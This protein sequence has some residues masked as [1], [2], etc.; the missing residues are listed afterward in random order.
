MIPSVFNEPVE[1]ISETELFHTKFGK[2]QRCDPKATG[3]DLVIVDL[4]VTEADHDPVLP[5]TSNHAEVDVVVDDSPTY[6]EPPRGAEMS[7]SGPECDKNGLVDVESL[8]DIDDKN[9]TTQP[10]SVSKS[11]V[12]P[13]SPACTRIRETYLGASQ[14][15][16]FVRNVNRNRFALSLPSSEATSVPSVPANLQK[17][18][19][20]A[21]RVG[22]QCV[23]SHVSVKLPRRRCVAS[24]P[25]T[26]MPCHTPPPPLS[27][28]TPTVPA[29]YASG[30]SPS[31]P[32][33][34]VNGCGDDSEGRQWKRLRRLRESAT[35]AAA[36]VDQK[37]EM[38]DT[39]K[40]SGSCDVA[41]TENGQASEST[42][43]F[44]RRRERERD[45]NDSNEDVRNEGGAAFGESSSVGSAVSEK[46]TLLEGVTSSGGGETDKE[47]DSNH[48]SDHRLGT[49]SPPGVVLHD[50][51]HVTECGQDLRAEVGKLFA[52]RGWP[53][54]TDGV[55]RNCI[56]VMLGLGKNLAS[57]TPTATKTTT[58]L[59]WASRSGP[60]PSTR[61]SNNTAIVGAAIL[62]VYKY[63]D[64]RR[65]GCL[66]F[67]VSAE[68]GI[69]G[70]L[71][72]LALR[73]LAR[74]D[75][76]CLFSGVDLS[77][78]K[79]LAAHTGWGFRAVERQT[80]AN[81]GLNF[82]E[83]GD[84]LYMSLPVARPS[85]SRG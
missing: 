25:H 37:G 15:F 31:T 64:R 16:F 79:A 19:V 49:S 29:P 2:A 50:F 61:N 76:W 22:L 48:S 55:T 12:R 8:S 24:L 23:R 18:V 65:C 38:Y 6:L 46:D 78:A 81:A 72:G 70:V 39:P 67:I 36:D 74:H 27:P 1:D 62:S 14:N 63:R 54:P 11:T 83:T 73:Y 35:A 44:R 45:S 33:A 75:V 3:D 9:Y 34:G 42:D 58:Y 51:V 85:S 56:G 32:G 52:G 40:G 13:R 68:R 60:R 5:T 47:N 41:V 66:E 71:V 84:V 28:G 10:I 82:Y 69:G 30:D 20:T 17:P 26:P 80:W 7:Q 4:T 77:R 43:S 57:P 21:S 53:G 59:A